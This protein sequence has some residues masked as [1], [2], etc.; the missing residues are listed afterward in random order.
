M[1]L[2]NDQVERQRGLREAEQ[3]FENTTV[4]G[5]GQKCEE[6][7]SWPFVPGIR[8]FKLFAIRN[9]S[10]KL[11]D[12]LKL[13]INI[14]DTLVFNEKK[15]PLFLLR[16]NSQGYLFREDINRNQDLIR[17]FKENTCFN[18][19]NPENKTD[20]LYKELSAKRNEN[21]FYMG[22][23]NKKHLKDIL[24]SKP[25]LIKKLFGFQSPKKLRKLKSMLRIDE[26]FR[27]IKKEKTRR[28]NFE[29]EPFVIVKRGTNKDGR[30]CNNSTIYT[31]KEFYDKCFGFMNSR[32]D[33]FVIQKYSRGPGATHAFVRACYSFEEGKPVVFFLSNK[34][35]INL[36]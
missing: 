3:P 8:F 36:I 10:Q 21:K 24:K 27:L 22:A 31:E 35:K 7:Y 26:G 32:E 23:S 25:K 33:L 1:H 2:R 19:Q 15:M 11:K 5:L 14:V 17:L 16:T 12:Y 28:L 4:K 18:K 20:D 13:K 6:A 30:I 29:K 34:D 9:K